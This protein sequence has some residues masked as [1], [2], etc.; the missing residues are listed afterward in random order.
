MT[1]HPLNEPPEKKKFLI[2]AFQTGVPPAATLTIVLH[3]EFKE[4]RS[5]NLR[6]F[7][8]VFVIVPSVPGSRAAQNNIPLTIVNDSFLV[9]PFSG[10]YAW[11]EIEPERPPSTTQPQ[12]PTNTFPQ[13]PSESI[14]LQYKQQNNLSDQQHAMVIGFSKQ[15]GLNYMFS[16]QCLIETNW[17]DAHA[18]QAFQSAKGGIPPE[19]FKL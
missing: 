4:A 7:D 6:S 2:E 10:N 9:R 1:Q 3:G 13:L 17:S 5:S 14:L 19:A 11:N 18:T 15:T 8:R 12:P 16:L